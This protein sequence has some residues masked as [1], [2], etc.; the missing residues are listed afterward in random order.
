[1]PLQLLLGRK[2]FRILEGESPALCVG[3]V[4]AERHGVEMRGVDLDPTGTIE[5]LVERGCR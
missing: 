1:M 5:G 3:F 2:E 4:N